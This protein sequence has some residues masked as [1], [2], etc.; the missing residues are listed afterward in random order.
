MYA[1][2]LVSNGHTRFFILHNSHFINSQLVKKRVRSID[3]ILCKALRSHNVFSM[4]AMI[5]RH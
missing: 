2:L 1:K 3:F 5:E 4:F